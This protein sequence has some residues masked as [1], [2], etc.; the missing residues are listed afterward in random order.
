[1]FSTIFNAH[2]VRSIL[3]LG[4]NRIEV[5]LTFD[6]GCICSLPFFFLLYYFATCATLV[7]FRFCFYTFFIQSWMDLDADD[8]ACD[9]PFLRVGYLFFLECVGEPH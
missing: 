8:D 2:R 5:R 1:M 3:L 4:D 9:E 7:H 6:E